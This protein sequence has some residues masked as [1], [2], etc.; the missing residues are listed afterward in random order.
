MLINHWPIRGLSVRTDRLELR[1]PTEEEL[2]EIADVAARGVHGP[3][4]RPFLTPWTDQPPAGRALD[5]MQTH[6]S[7]LGRWTPKDWALDLVAFHEGRPIGMQDLR[8]V[9]F[10]VRREIVSGSWLGLEHHGRGLGTEMRL[11]VLHLAFAELGAVSATSASFTDNHSA[12]TVSRKLGYRPDGIT[13]DVL[14]GEVVESQRFRLSREDWYGRE[15]PP[16][17]VSGFAGCEA[18]FGIG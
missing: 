8:A 17:T 12:L 7:R 18:L 4:E 5:V 2:A 6:W 3:D 16:V 9:D 1:L 10:G 14:H 13:R 15:R 11:A